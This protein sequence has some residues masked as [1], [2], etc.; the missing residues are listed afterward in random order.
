MLKE[1][2]LNI[3]LEGKKFRIRQLPAVDG[4]KFLL[5][6]GK[7]SGGIFKGFNIDVYFNSDDTFD[8]E[9]MNIS[10]MV[11]SV[12]EGLDEEKSAQMIKKVVNKSVLTPKDFEF[13]IDLAGEYDLIIQLIY[14]IM[15]LNYKKSLDNLKKKL[16]ENQAK[17]LKKI[18]TSLGKKTTKQQTIERK[19]N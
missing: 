2:D 17:I 5:F 18:Q 7:I 3:E 9:E 11:S 14:E 16:V 4:L 19:M 15:S 8:F 1:K 12:I 6:L 10:N 13:D